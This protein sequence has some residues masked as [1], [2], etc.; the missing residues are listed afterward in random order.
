MADDIR[1]TG[2]QSYRDLQRQNLGNLSLED[3]WKVVQA[4]RQANPNM[5]SSEAVKPIGLAA[6]SAGYG[7]YQY[8]EGL[9][10]ESQLADLEDVRYNNQPWYDVLANGVGKMLGTAATTFLS[11]TVGF[12]YG[13]GKA[14][15]NP[16]QGREGSLSAIWDN[17]VTDALTQVDDW[18][19]RNMTNY[20]SQAQKADP[21]FRLGDMNWWADNVIKNVGFTL[22]AAGAMA[23]TAGGF[24]LMA[25]SL[26][27]V[28]KVG[29][30]TKGAVNLT[31]SL[32]A[33][34]GEGMIEAK[35]GVDGRNKLAIEQFQEGMFRFEKQMGSMDIS[36]GG[37]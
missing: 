6:M 8:D 23:T 15:P 31:S 10:S 22:G 34:T 1:S 27:L 32:I 28:D 36:G 4:T 3:Q 11:S 30:I 16:W 13:L 29:N 12:G 21:T 18:M 7:N 17:E 20:Q 5:F 24:G 2:P 33:A 37:V 25:K 9:T 26:N 14:L 35:H 19:E